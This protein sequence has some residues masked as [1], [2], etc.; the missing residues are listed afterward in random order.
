VKLYVPA[1]KKKEYFSHNKLV[2]II[3]ALRRLKQR[4]KSSRLAWATQQDSASKK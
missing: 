2:P 3:P 4:I 1:K